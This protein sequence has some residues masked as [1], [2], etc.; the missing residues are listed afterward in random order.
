MNYLQTYNNNL[1]NLAINSWQEV[2]FSHP[3]KY[4]K[5]H[6]ESPLFSSNLVWS[7]KSAHFEHPSWLRN[8]KTK[9]PQ[10]SSL[11]FF[12]VR[13]LHQDRILESNIKQKE[14]NAHSK[15][16]QLLTIINV[17]VRKLL[18]A[19]DLDSK[20]C[21][22]AAYYINFLHSLCIYINHTKNYNPQIMGCYLVLRKSLIHSKKPYDE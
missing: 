17:S 9:D 14:S 11:L 16:Q 6:M 18:W 3:W 21:S 20:K 1:P 12:Q 8:L 2:D 13:I 7:F 10:S 4:N 15:F 5:Q 19:K 22:V